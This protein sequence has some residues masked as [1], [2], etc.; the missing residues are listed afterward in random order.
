METIQKVSCAGVNERV[1]RLLYGC[2]VL[3]QSACFPH[4]QQ[5]WSTHSN[6]R[7]LQLDG[8]DHETEHFE[9]NNTKAN[10][11][12]SN[13]RRHRRR[14]RFLSKSRKIFQAAITMETTGQSFVHQ[15]MATTTSWFATT[16]TA[17]VF[18]SNHS[19]IERQNWCWQHTRKSML[20]FAKLRS[21]INQRNNTCT[22]K[23][24]TFH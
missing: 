3:D 10:T 14:K 5:A 16:T 4:H 8:R 18:W 13:R 19:N 6:L 21:M 22:Q 2:L 9:I 15:V 23:R 17:T 20:D 11:N 7:D 1:C 12:Q 24:S